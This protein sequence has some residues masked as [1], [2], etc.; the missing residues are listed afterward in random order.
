MRNKTTI[1]LSKDTRDRLANLCH[2]DETFEEKVSEL[3]S[4]VEHI[5]K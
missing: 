2:K 5:K 4:E 3:I 1:E